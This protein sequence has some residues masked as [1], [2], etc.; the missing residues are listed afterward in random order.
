MMVPEASAAHR[1]FTN[2]LFGVPLVKRRPERRV[3]TDVVTG[4]QDLRLSR[5]MLLRRV[6]LNKM[7]DTGNQ[8]LTDTQTLP[9]MDWDFTQVPTLSNQF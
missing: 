3:H 6:P 5:W 2:R 4:G 9:V 1:Q 7:M 8:G